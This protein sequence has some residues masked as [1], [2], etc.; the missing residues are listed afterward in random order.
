MWILDMLD[1]EWHIA[2]PEKIETCIKD[3]LNYVKD[4]LNYVCIIYLFHMYI[5]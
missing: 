3:V 2:T 1:P 4:V 5:T